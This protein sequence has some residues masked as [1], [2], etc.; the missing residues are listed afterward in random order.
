[1]SYLG[2]EGPLSEDDYQLSEE[3]LES[4]GSDELLK[5]ARKVKMRK[6]RLEIP[7][8]AISSRTLGTSRETT[9]PGTK[10]NNPIAFRNVKLEAK[11]HSQPSKVAN[12]RN[13]KDPHKDLR[14]AIKEEVTSKLEAAGNS[15]TN[16]RIPRLLALKGKKIITVHT[17][18]STYSTPDMNVIIGVHGD[19]YDVAIQ[20]PK[21]VFK[22]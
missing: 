18:G 5:S 20:N 12:K 4:F 22:H 16:P 21:M 10:G 17:N 8:M 2:N 14:N 11:P 19:R 9:P 6:P 15:N 7:T 1:M 3:I 13:P